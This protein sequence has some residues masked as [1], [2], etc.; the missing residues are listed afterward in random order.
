MYGPDLAHPDAES[1][2]AGYVDSR[3]PPESAMNGRTVHGVLL[4]T[5]WG[6]QAGRHLSPAQLAD[7]PGSNGRHGKRSLCMA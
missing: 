1:E 6:M 5:T 4:S 2:V 3:G 7:W